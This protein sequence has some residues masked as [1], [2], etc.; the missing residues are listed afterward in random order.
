MLAAKAQLQDSNQNTSQGMPT[1][2]LCC[3]RLPPL[4][5]LCM[6]VTHSFGTTVPERAVV[7]CGIGQ[8]SEALWMTVASTLSNGCKRFAKGR[9]VKWHA[10]GFDVTLGTN[11]ISKWFA[12]VA[13]GSK[14][15]T[16]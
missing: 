11:T 14:A 7:G 9:V 3:P 15:N 5:L 2:Y 10:H 12:K 16:M 4:Y 6:M 1:K 8:N 13:M